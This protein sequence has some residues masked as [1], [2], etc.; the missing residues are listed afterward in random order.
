MY[1]FGIHLVDFLVCL[2]FRLYFLLLFLHAPLGAY[3]VPGKWVD[4][5]ATMNVARILKEAMIT[6]IMGGIAVILEEI[7][8]SVR[9]MTG[10]G[11]EDDQNLVQGVGDEKQGSHWRSRFLH[12]FYLS[13]LVR[14][15]STLQ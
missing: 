3:P 11:V 2:E 10:R 6:I 9:L 14:C 1:H 5:G 7:T 15:V 13:S 12:L 4:E 8:D